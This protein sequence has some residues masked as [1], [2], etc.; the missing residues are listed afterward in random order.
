M[1]PGRAPT[2]PASDD[3]TPAVERLSFDER[4]RPAMEEVFG[5]F[6]IARDLDLALNMARAH[7]INCVTL[8]G[9][10]VSSKMA[11]Q[12]PRHCQPTQ[13]H[14]DIAHSGHSEGFLLLHAA[15]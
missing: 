6:F 12:G 1:R 8:G 2:V 5:K 3:V 7:S 11:I 4:F 9:D 13:R 14:N 15:A 10:Q